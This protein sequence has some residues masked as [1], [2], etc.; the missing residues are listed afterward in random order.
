MYK[1][2]ILKNKNTAGEKI[3]KTKVKQ[4]YILCWK[5]KTEKKKNQ[6]TFT[7]PSDIM[8]MLLSE[9]EALTEST[10]QL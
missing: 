3:K 1:R 5:N 10:S 8:S 9:E 2:T 4:K 7:I 6:P